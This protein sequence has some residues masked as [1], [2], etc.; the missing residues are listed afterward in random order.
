MDFELSARKNKL[1]LTLNLSGSKAFSETTRE[2]TAILEGTFRDLAR[3]EENI[4]KSYR[5]LI[6]TG[7]IEAVALGVR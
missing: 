7:I 6:S 4:A 3:P 2:W 1:R 5:F